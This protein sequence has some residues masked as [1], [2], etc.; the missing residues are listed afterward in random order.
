MHLEKL[1]KIYNFWRPNS[2]EQKWQKITIK[3]PRQKSEKEAG[4]EIEASQG[5]YLDR[6]NVASKKQRQVGQ[7]AFEQA[8]KHCQSG[9]V[10]IKFF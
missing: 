1:W 7:V 9:L 2:Q 5:Q 3:I 4:D 10:L 8:T 6:F